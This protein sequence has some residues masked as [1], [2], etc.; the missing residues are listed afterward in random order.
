MKTLTVSPAYGQDYLSA[1]AALAAWHAG[2]DFQQHGVNATGGRY[3][4]NRDVIR[5]R[6]AGITHIA[7]RYNHMRSVVPVQLRFGRELRF[8]RSE[9]R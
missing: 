1:H 8:G 2:E 5:L 7:I 4:S 9:P 3:L 6:D